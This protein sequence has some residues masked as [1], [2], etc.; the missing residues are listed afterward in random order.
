MIRSYFFVATPADPQMI[1]SKRVVQV[2]T[3]RCPRETMPETNSKT[4]GSRL[5][6]VKRV[7][8]VFVVFITF[9]LLSLLLSLP[10]IF[11]E[12][13]QN[14]APPTHSE[15]IRSGD[16]KSMMKRAKDVVGG[17]K[18]LDILR[19][20]FER[21]GFV[22]V[23]PRFPE[24]VLEGAKEF[25]EK[26]YTTCISNPKPPKECVNFHQDRYTHNDGVKSLALDADVLAVLAA[27]NGFKPYPFQTLNYPTTS[28]ACTHSDYVHFAPHPRHLM[29]GVWVALQDIDPRSGPV[30]YYPG[31]HRKD[32]YSMQDFGLQPRQHHPHNYPKYQDIMEASMNISGLKRHTAILK[33][34]EALI[35]TSNL[36]HGGPPPEVERLRRLSQ[37]S[38]YFFEGADYN[39]AP[40]MSDVTEDKIIY[41][42][43]EQ[44]KRKWHATDV[45][46]DERFAMSKFREGHCHDSS[47]PQGIAGPCDLPNR[48]PRVFS[49]ILVH[50]NFDG[51]VVM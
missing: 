26:V 48:P 27:L 49:E 33:K 8:S 21:N 36:V 42:S 25:T 43:E 30:F 32:F 20:I 11:N 23:K 3:P 5:F 39:W 44:V 37:V 14:D 41:Y 38:H 19:R 35:W 24:G 45:N 7:T 16:Y 4:Y 15:F 6:H 40:V 47:V 28:K 51:E 13:T 10:G 2:F 31:S 22:I 18:E 17:T 12:V 1:F 46:A 9:K 29:C 50:E 34:G